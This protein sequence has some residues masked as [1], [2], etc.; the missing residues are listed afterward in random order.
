MEHNWWSVISPVVGL[1]L[2]VIAQILGYRYIN[3]LS[4][5]RSVYFG[6]GLGLFG[7]ILLFVYCYW[8]YP[9]APQTGENDNDS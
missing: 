7:M 3:R 6:F 2:N 4:L 1:I 9:D 8:A 5:L